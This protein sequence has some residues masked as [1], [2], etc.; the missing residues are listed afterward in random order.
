M[1][2]TY[3]HCDYGYWQYEC[4]AIEKR[5]LLQVFDLLEINWL[6]KSQNA[7]A[8]NWATIIIVDTTACSIIIIEWYD[9]A[10]WSSTDKWLFK[11]LLYITGLQLCLLHMRWLQWARCTWACAKDLI[12]TMVSVINACIWWKFMMSLRCVYQAVVGLVY[13]Y[14]TTPQ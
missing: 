1:V 7:K 11:A 2:A 5:H 3:I 8:N 12:Y 13:V 14:N 9:L 10:W 6:G 4:I